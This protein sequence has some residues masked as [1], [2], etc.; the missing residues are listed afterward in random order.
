MW[1]DLMWSDLR[2]E[3]D[4][5][6]SNQQEGNSN[7]KPN[8]NDV[9]KNSTVHVGWWPR[10]W[11]GTSLTHGRVERIQDSF[12][13]CRQCWDRPFSV[14]RQCSVS[15]ST[16]VLYRVLTTATTGSCPYSTVQYL[17]KTVQ[18]CP[19]NNTS[20]FW[21]YPGFVHTEYSI[22]IYS[23]INMFTTCL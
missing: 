7:L 4:Y 12:Q 2:K 13:S 22:G 14:C 17:I 5:D 16:V 20:A 18:A 15:Y 10:V 19:H 23:G 11:C 1:C 8:L 9:C 21:A 6:E 3:E